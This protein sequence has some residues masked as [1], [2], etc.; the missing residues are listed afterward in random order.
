ML[1]STKRNVACQVNENNKCKIKFSRSFFFFFLKNFHFFNFLFN[2]WINLSL[3][4]TNHTNVWLASN[5]SQP[6]KIGTLNL[7][8]SRWFKIKISFC[9][10]WLDCYEPGL[11]GCLTSFYCGSISHKVCCTF[12]P[13]FGCYALPRR[14]K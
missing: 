4:I 6:E 13:A 2:F 1:E 5:W 3:W 10:L 7:S 11:G 8:Y 14:S 9:W 12:W